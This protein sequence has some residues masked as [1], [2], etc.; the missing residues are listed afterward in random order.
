MA[1]KSYLDIRIPLEG[2]FWSKER[3]D[4]YRKAKW[5]ELEEEEDRKFAIKM[6]KLE[7]EQAAYNAGFHP[8]AAPPGLSPGDAIKDALSIFDFAFGAKGDK[9]DDKKDTKDNPIS[10]LFSGLFS[11]VGDSLDKVKSVLIIVIVVVAGLFIFKMFR[12]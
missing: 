2:L 8:D 3:K 1:A 11:G 6:Q 5:L 4:E 7:I 12:K 9:S 10:N